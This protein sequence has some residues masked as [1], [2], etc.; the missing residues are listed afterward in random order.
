MGLTGWRVQRPLPYWAPLGAVG[1]VLIAGG[2]LVLV[3]AFVCFV[4]EG[5]GTPAPVAPTE[6]LVIDRF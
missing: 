3:H 4:A 2:T 6:R 5:S 1:A